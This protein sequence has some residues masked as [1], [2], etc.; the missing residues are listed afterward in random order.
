MTLQDLKDIVSV[1]VLLM[2]PPLLAMAMY[3]LYQM[4]KGLKDLDK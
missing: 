2:V 3:C 1:F 4:I